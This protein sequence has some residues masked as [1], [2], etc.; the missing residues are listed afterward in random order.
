DE[1]ED[2]HRAERPAPS[3]VNGKSA[4]ERD[5]DDAAEGTTGHEGSGERGSAVGREDGEDDGQA[6]A[7]VRGLPDADG[8]AGEEQL[9][10]ADR[11]GGRRGGDAP[12]DRHED[13]RADPTQ[14][15]ASSDSGTARM[16]TARA[17]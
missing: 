15:S 12:D 6:D 3:E 17:T 16:P 4:A 1:A 10:V 11:E 7:A 8:Q 13:D 9:V 14:R 2:G 5:P